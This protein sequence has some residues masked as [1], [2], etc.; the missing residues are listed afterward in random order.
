MPWGASV[1][2]SPLPSVRMTR[3][4]PESVPRAMATAQA[5]ITQNGGMLAESSTAP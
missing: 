2:T 3:Q 1:S 4:P 5:A